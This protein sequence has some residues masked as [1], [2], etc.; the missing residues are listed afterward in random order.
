MKAAVWCVCWP[1]WE[2]RGDRSLT[3][4]SL[5]KKRMLFPIETFVE[6]DTVWD[7]CMCKC[8]SL[9]NLLQVVI[10][11]Q[12]K[13]SLDKSIDDVLT[14]QHNVVPFKYIILLYYL[15]IRH[16]NHMYSCICLSCSSARKVLFHMKTLSGYKVFC[17]HY[18]SPLHLPV[19]V[20]DCL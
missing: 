7:C 4:T 2:G 6:S 17:M 19:C 11:K 9:L 16:Y 8:L 5:C 1:P 13:Y 3:A 15:I 12:G 10:E 14:A 20:G 18:Q